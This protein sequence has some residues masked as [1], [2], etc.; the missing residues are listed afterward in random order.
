MSKVLMNAPE[1]YE[2]LLTAGCYGPDKLARLPPIARI[3][4][5]QEC[6]A[7]IDIWSAWRFRSAGFDFEELDALVMF[8]TARVTSLKGW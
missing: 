7:F 8:E 6:Q 2:V 4:G 3:A 1:G 5:F